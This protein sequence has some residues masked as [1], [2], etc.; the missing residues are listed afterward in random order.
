MQLG[1]TKAIKHSEEVVV[2]FYSH[3]SLNLSWWKEGSHDYYLWLRV[4]MGA[5][6][7]LFICVVYVAP[8]GSK[9]ESESL[10]QNLVAINVEVQTLKGIVLLGGDFNVRTVVLLDT[11]DTSD[12]CELL[13]EPE[14]VEIKQPGVVVKRQNHNAIVGG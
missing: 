2:Y 1:K 9:H 13:Q 8:V 6:P 10:F 7:K 5:A 11:I 12:L 14:F 4:N 3:F